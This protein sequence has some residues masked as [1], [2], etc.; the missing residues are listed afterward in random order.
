[1]CGISAVF[2]SHTFKEASGCKGYTIGVTEILLASEM[3]GLEPH[4]KVVLVELLTE[5]FDAG[6]APR[7]DNKRGLTLHKTSFTT[8]Y[9]PK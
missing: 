9:D 5:I 6:A 7:R 8:L 3:E 1:M 4:I 2:S